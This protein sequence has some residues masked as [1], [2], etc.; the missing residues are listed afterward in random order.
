MLLAVLDLVCPWSHNYDLGTVPHSA[1][2]H[3]V[4]ALTNGV[5]SAMM[6]SLLH[7]SAWSLV[8]VGGG[9]KRGAGRRLPLSRCTRSRSVDRMIVIEYE[10]NDRYRI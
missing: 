9:G 10:G 1:P 4:K 5:S 8:R 2:L 3:K 7:R 6:L